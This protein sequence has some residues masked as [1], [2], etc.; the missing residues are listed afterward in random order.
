MDASQL[1]S[2]LKQAAL[3]W[4]CVRE[5][6]FRA[7]KP[8]LLEINGRESML[9]GDGTLGKKDESPVCADSTLIKEL[10]ELFSKHSLYAY[11]EEIGQGF[12][13]IEGGHR[14][15][16]SGKAVTAGGRIRTLK[17]ISF[18]NLRLA[19]ERKGCADRVLP[20]LFSQGEFYDTLIV[21]PPGAG[22]TTLLRELVRQISNGSP[23]AEGKNVS[24]VDER[25]EIAAC[26]KGVPQCDLGLRTD[27]M[28][29][30]PKGRGMVMMLRSMSPQ[31]LAVDEAGTKEELEAL[32]YGMNCGCKILA[33]AH[34]TTPEDIKRKPVLSDMAENKLFS[35][36]V[37]L[38]RIPQPGTVAG[39][40]DENFCPVFEGREKEDRRREHNSGGRIKNSGLGEES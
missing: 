32:L 7:G 36:Y 18:L 31:V 29:G 13:T 33:T 11:E 17:D 6:R 10:L 16:I 15:G 30:C 38:S 9:Y 21:S 14:V 20:W 27:V 39:I 25:S 23:Y 12:L 4:E 24:V 40:Y 3:P 5:I 2:L 1:R 26:Y 19:H 35:R 8:V 34:G 28:D 37:F 22:K